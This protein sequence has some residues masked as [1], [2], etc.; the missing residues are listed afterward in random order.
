VVRAGD[1]TPREASTSWQNACNARIS[2]G[3]RHWTSS[4]F[5]LASTTA[6]QRARETATFSRFRD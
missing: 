2:S 3:M 6:K 5:G 4:S 1:A